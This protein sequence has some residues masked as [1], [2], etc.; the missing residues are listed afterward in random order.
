MDKQRTTEFLE[1]KF[2]H[3]LVRTGDYT[4]AHCLDYDLVA[5]ADNQD[6]AIRRLNLVVRSHIEVARKKDMLTALQ[7]RAPDQYWQ[8]LASARQG[9]EILNLEV[10]SEPSA[11]VTLGVLAASAHAIQ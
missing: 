11:T 7:H 6:E 2:L 5:V 4:V 8:E 9:L 1:P 10:Q 3:Y